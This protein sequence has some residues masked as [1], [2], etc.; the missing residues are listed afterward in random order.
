MTPLRYIQ[1]CSQAGSTNPVTSKAVRILLSAFRM[2]DFDDIWDITLTVATGAAKR[3]KILAAFG[4]DHTVTLE[5]R[6]N[7][8]GVTTTSL[9]TLPGTVDEHLTALTIDPNNTNDLAGWLSIVL[10]AIHNHCPRKPVA[11]G[12]FLG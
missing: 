6:I 2:L 5:I 8:T 11:D 3:V 12:Y 10:S 7:P 9:T 4:P 1:L